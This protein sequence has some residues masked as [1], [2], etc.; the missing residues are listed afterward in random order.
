MPF[1]KFQRLSMNSNSKNRMVVDALVGRWIHQRKGWTRNQWNFMWDWKKILNFLLRRTVLRLDGN[2]WVFSSDGKCPITSS[3][4][5]FWPDGSVCSRKMHAP[6]GISIV[7]NSE[8]VW[9]AYLSS[10]FW[11]FD[12][13]SKLMVYISFRFIKHPKHLRLEQWMKNIV[14]FSKQNLLIWHMSN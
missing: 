7:S 12:F 6:I 14:D 10:K 9:I 11:S 5:W 2:Y 3:R 13:S 1:D 4:S 8:I